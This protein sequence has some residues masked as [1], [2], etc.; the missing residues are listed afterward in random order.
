MTRGSTIHNL[1]TILTMLE[2][3]NKMN[4][5]DKYYDQIEQKK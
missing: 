2:K 4:E 3:M 1:L 5:I